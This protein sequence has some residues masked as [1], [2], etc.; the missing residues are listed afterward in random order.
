MAEAGPPDNL[1][2]RMA[3]VFVPISTPFD[4]TEDID[5]DALTLNVERYAASGVLGYLALGSN[6][7]NRSLTEMEKYAVM[8]PRISG[9]H[10]VFDHCSLPL[11]HP[12]RQVPPPAAICS[13]G[14]PI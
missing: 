5:F 1:S 6:G 8:E 7:E 4:A 12:T 10:R 13:N 11:P 3:G 14:N 2:G 9:S